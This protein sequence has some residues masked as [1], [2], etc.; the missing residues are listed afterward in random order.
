MARR[1]FGRFTRAQARACGPEAPSILASGLRTGR[2]QRLT[3]R[4]LCVVGAQRGWVGDLWTACLHVGTES[5]VS[6]RSAARLHGLP[7]VAPSTPC[8]TVRSGGDRGYGYGYGDGRVFQQGDLAPGQVVRIGG[9]TVTS[10]AR[11]IVDL[12]PGTTKHRLGIWLDHAIAERIVSPD[13]LI[14][15]MRLCD[16]RGKPSLDALR[17]LVVDYL[18]DPRTPDGA[19]VAALEHVIRLAGLPPGVTWFHRRGDD[20]SR[21]LVDRSWLQARLILECDGRAPRDRALARLSDRRRDAQAV[22]EGWRTLRYVHEQFV[23]AP[24]ETA[25]TVRGIYEQRML[26][27]LESDVG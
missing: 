25:A 26:Q 24:A 20:A 10:A 22:V 17:D 27:L 23:A 9:L 12:A 11:T 7:G 18:P 15:V 2:W 14:A 4:V 6:H 19:S 3:P 1:Q 13:E 16:R 5:V 21:G 8:V